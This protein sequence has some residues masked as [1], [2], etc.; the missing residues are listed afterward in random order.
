MA[1]AAW[2]ESKVTKYAKV[3]PKIFYLFQT[4]L[5]MLIQALEITAK[6]SLVSEFIKEATDFVRFGFDNPSYQD[7]VL[8]LQKQSLFKFDLFP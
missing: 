3:I 8:G 2:Q 4:H 7:N 6:P 1:G 5:E